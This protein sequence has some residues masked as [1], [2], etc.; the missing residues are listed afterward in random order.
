VITNLA[1]ECCLPVDQRCVVVTGAPLFPDLGDSQPK[2]AQRGGKFW[3]V[4]RMGRT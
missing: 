2:T 4:W 1:F 3:V